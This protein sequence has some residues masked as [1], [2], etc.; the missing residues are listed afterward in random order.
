MLEFCLREHNV[1]E[2]DPPIIDNSEAP[3]RE[4]VPDWLRWLA[5][6]PAALIGGWLGRGCG[7]VFNVLRDVGGVEHVVPFF[8]LLPGGLGFTIA[9]ALVAPR[10]RRTIA[11]GLAVLSVGQTL[12]VHLL[13]PTRLGR[14]N[15]LHA[16]GECLGA[17]AGVMLVLFL[18]RQTAR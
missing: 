14:V 13:L 11:V 2:G 3:D 8:V 6:I 4:P 10:R 12:L 15:Y 9:G 5:V 17:I 1:T 7:A 18:D 16:V